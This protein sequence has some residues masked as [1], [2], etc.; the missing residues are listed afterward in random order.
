M[1]IKILHNPRCSKSRETLKMLQESGEEINIVEYLKNPPTP[2]E[3]ATFLESLGESLIRKKEDSYKKFQN[4]PFSPKAW[5][6]ILHEN[7][8]LIERPLVI[9][10]K[11]MVIGRPPEKVR[12]LL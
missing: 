4:I 7:P 3:L 1:K 6:V 11:S 9:K 2:S 12:S 5:A 10:G 8:K